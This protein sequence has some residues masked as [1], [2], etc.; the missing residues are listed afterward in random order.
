MIKTLNLKFFYIPLG[1]WLLLFFCV[2]YIFIFSVLPESTQQGLGKK[3]GDYGWMTFWPTSHLC[4]YLICSFFFPD[5]WFFLYMVGFLWEVFEIVYSSI[6]VRL[7]QSTSYWFARYFDLLMNGMGVGIGTSLGMILRHYQNG[8]V[9]KF[10]LKIF[11]MTFTMSMV[12][13]FFDDGGHYIRP[14][15][16]SD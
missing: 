13:L 2:L 4:F 1:L 6:K 16:E 14:K 12:F 8:K 15:C 11:F 10:W 7:K 5:Y 9:L 3:F